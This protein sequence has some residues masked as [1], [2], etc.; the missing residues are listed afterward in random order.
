MSLAQDGNRKMEKTFLI[1]VLTL[2]FS[3]CFEETPKEAYEITDEFCEKLKDMNNLSKT[4]KNEFHA[5]CLT[6]G[7]GTFV[8]SED[9][10][11]E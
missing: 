9:I 6:R 1:L 2:L 5:K 4:E 8:P 3:G 11:W 7:L 10:G